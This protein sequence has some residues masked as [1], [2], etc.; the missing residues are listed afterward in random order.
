MSLPAPLI[1]RDDPGAERAGCGPH[2]AGFAG[3][4]GVRHLAIIMDGNGR[5]AKARGQV[6][7][8]GH[9]AGVEALRR[10]VEAAGDLGL[11]VLTV[12]AFSTENWRRPPAEVDWL[13]ALLRSYVKSDLER[14]NKAG[15]RIAVMGRQDGLPGDILDLIAMAEQATQLNTSM[16]L[17]IAFNYGGQAEIVDAM[18][19]IATQVSL[20]RVAPEAIDEA[21]IARHLGTARWPDPDAI[22]RTS[23]E[24]RL[25]NFMLWQAAYAEF[26]CMDTYWPDFG[27]AELIVAM[28]AFAG[29]QRRFGA[30]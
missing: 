28:E 20:G 7:G 16:T 26:I 21:L 27:K 30:V 19:A 14:L 11:E 4:C 9:N 13:F 3:R 29:R 8:F 23:G 2:D 15:V 25:S 17:V 5:W 6:R 18:K 12:Y 24:M 22:V 10:T 1:E